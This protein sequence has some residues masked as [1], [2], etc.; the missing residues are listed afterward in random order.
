MRSRGSASLAVVL[1]T[2]LSSCNSLPPPPGSENLG[3]YALTAE[4][5]RALADGGVGELG[6]DGGPRCALPEVVPSAVSFEARI[7]REPSTG[8]AWLTLGP[9]YPR[10]ATWDG[11]VLESEATVPRLFPSCAACVKVVAVERIRF[12][13]LSRSQSEAVGRR[14]PANPLDGGVPAPPGPNGEI[15]APAQTSEGFD[16]LYTCGDLTFSVNVLEGGADCPE[17]CSQCVVSYTLEGERR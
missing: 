7:T 8:E 11:Q 13:L 2:W 6:P 14:C 15:T 12:A 3:A 16:A 9:G 4:P 17:A 5:V 10:E 1:L